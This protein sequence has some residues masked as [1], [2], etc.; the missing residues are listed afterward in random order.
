MCFSAPASFIASGSLAVLGGTSLIVAKKKDKLLAAIP[1]M[2]SFQQ[3]FEGI[4]WLYLNAN[5]S[6]LIA[7]YGFL[8]FALIIWPIYVP[9]FVYILDKKRR[10]ILKWFIF[11]G[12]AVTLYF[13]WL[14]L[15]QSLII[16]EVK[17]CVS[18]NFN[19]PF[20][21]VTTVIYLLVIIGPLLISS[22]QIFKWFGVVITILGIISWYFYSVTFTSV[23]CFFAA[24]ISSM[25]FIYII[26][27]K[28]IH[29][30]SV[31]KKEN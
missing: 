8:L 30:I 2:F 3:M 9:T 14:L 27:K 28:N 4:Q 7:G 11:L 19:L 1:L 21:N 18:Y 16:H 6:S 12:I 24:I 20:Q 29:S 13:L 26:F 22:Q 15:T 5:S 10:W 23:W 25:F 17:A 31:S